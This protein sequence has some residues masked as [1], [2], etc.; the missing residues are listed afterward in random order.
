MPL[1][2]PGTKGHKRPLVV[3]PTFRARPS[4]TELLAGARSL[5]AGN[6]AY[7]DLL[8]HPR[9]YGGDARYTPGGVSQV[10]LAGGIRRMETGDGFQPL[11]ISRCRPKRLLVPLV[12]PDLV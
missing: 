6:G 9:W 2:P 1:H 3:P 12:R 5:P 7:R 8:L 4:P 10:K 11:A